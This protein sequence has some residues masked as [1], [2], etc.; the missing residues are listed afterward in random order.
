MGDGGTFPIGTTTETYTATDATG[1]TSSCSF[2]VTV[3]D[4]EAPEITCPVDMT[5]GNDLGN[6]D[7]VVNYTAPAGTDNCGN[8]TT[9][10]TG[11]L[12]DGDTFPFGN[13]TETYTT[14]DAA[15]NTSSCSFTIT[16][17]DTEAPVISCPPDMTISNDLGNCD[18]LVSYSVPTG[19]DNCGNPVIV[20]TGG[21]GDGGTFPLGSNVET[22]TATDAV[23]N[24]S[25][26][27][28]TITVKDVDPP[29]FACPTGN[30]VRTTDL[31][32]CDHLAVDQDLDPAVS[33]CSIL[34]LTNDYNQSSSLDGAVFS[35]GRTQVTWTATD[36]SGNS[37]A[38]TYNIRINDREAPV[39]DNCPADT[40]ITIPFGVGGSY[41]TWPALTATDNCNSPNKLTISAAFH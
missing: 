6:C 16:V 22:Y 15:G 33:D 40:T 32:M 9:V 7:A 36:A 2:T 41:H 21:L 29:V 27:S 1:N 13:N 20:Q 37:T 30:V 39:F 23:G 17:N 35:K 24:T 19:T 5:V 12:G 25:S 26:C 31:G 10:Q 28:F 3:N 38:C 8:P 4:T 34:T 11:G 14:T 18:A